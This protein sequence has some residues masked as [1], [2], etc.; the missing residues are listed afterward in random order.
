MSCSRSNLFTIRSAGDY[1][2]AANEAAAS[3]SS[4]AYRYVSYK[5]YVG[6]RPPP[7][8]E[9]NVIRETVLVQLPKQMGPSSSFKM[10]RHIT[11]RG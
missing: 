10:Q 9:T 5:T 6:M 11:E 7:R 3:S 1:V 4:I 8:R 2:G